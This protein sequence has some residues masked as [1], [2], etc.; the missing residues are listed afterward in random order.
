MVRKAAT[1]IDL[2]KAWRF[3]GLKGREDHRSPLYISES[4]TG[5][6]YQF[7]EARELGKVEKLVKG[8]ATI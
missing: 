2:A 6:K 5:I 8:L 7:L 3:F 1:E 4:P